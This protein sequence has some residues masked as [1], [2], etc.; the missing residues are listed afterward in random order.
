MI[1][2]ERLRLLTEPFYLLN[3]NYIQFFDISDK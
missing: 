2:F 1:Y 3:D